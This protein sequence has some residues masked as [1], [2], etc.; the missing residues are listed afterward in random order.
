M[1]SSFTIIVHVHSYIISSYSVHSYCIT[2][3]ETLATV[4]HRTT[5]WHTH[6][7]RDRSAIDNMERYIYVT[8]RYLRKKIFIETVSRKCIAEGVSVFVPPSAR[9]RGA[10]D[11]YSSITENY[12]PK[13][14]GE[15][16]PIVQCSVAE[17]RLETVLG[18]LSLHGDT[19]L[20]CAVIRITCQYHTHSEW[21]PQWY[22]SG[23]Q[24]H[25]TK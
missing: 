21:Q 2:P 5:I 24:H 14:W 15:L 13:I 6:T 3:A 12:G 7:Y 22:G 17:W 9:G 11:L 18:S 8:K 19:V 1:P 25:S 4:I 20:C 23:G 10:Q 16:S